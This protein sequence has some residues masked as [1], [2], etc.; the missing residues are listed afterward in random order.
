MLW[1]PQ[2]SIDMAR[3]ETVETVEGGTGRSDPFPSP[4]NNYLGCH[5]PPNVLPSLLNTPHHLDTC[6]TIYVLFR[7]PHPYPGGHGEP[8]QSPR[9]PTPPLSPLSEGG[10][11]P[12]DLS[13][14]ES[15]RMFFCFV[16]GKFFVFFSKAK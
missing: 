7:L 1:V 8:Q 3:A 4:Q 14:E 10:A 12:R 2:E 11:P 15:G 16:V 9:A 6:H 5:G 13:G